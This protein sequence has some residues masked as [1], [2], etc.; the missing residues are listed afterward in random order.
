MSKN[1]FIL[2][3][4]SKYRVM[5]N[6]FHA[7]KVL[8]PANL[9]RIRV[10]QIINEDGFYK[11]NWK[12]FRRFEL[13]PVKL[14]NGSPFIQLRINGM[15][16]P[17]GWNIAEQEIKGHLPY[18]KDGIDPETG[19]LKIRRRTPMMVFYAIGVTDRRK[20]RY[21]YLLQGPNGNLVGTRGD[22]QAKHITSWYMSKKQRN[23]PELEL[24]RKRRAARKERKIEKRF[25]RRYGL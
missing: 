20:Y 18:I 7:D 22:L 19:E 16:C 15:T 5:F 4:L 9:I 23:A 13:A 25:R 10:Q 1:W 3:V 14:S 17:G 6:R 24:K 12:G 11:E 21:L 2:V 8:K